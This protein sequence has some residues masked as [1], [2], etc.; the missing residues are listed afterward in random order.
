MIAELKDGKGHPVKKHY[1]HALWLPL[2]TDGGGN[3]LAFD[4]DPASGGTRGQ[5]IIIGADEDERRVL[6][7]GI[8]AFLAGL[9]PLLDVGRLTIGPPEDDDRPVVFFEFE[10]GML[11]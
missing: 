2:A 5:I 9:A 1:S 11:Q 4:L 6:A 8:G 7:P 10:P 3:S